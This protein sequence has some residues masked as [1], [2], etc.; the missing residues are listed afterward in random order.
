MF[1]FR[2]WTRRPTRT[3]R[4][5]RTPRLALTSL[6]D[7]TVPTSVT[8]TR[9]ANGAVVM[10]S[11]ASAVGSPATLLAIQV[12]VDP[13][14]GQTFVMGGTFNPHSHTVPSFDLGPFTFPASGTSSHLFPSASH[15][16]QYSIPTTGRTFSSPSDLATVAGGGSF[17]QPA[18]MSTTVAADHWHGLGT[19]TF[20]T[21]TT[22]VFDYTPALAA[23]G[24]LLAPE[25]QRTVLTPSQLRWADQDTAP[26]GLVYTVLAA[27]GRGTLYR[28]QMPLG[29]NSTFT[30][31][32]VD[33]GLIAYVHDGSETTSDGFVYNLR[34]ANNIPSSA[35]FGITVTPA[36]DAPVAADAAGTVGHRDAAGVSISLSATDAE[37][38]P[39]TYSLVGANG[40]AAHGTVTLNG[41]VAHYTP[42]GDVVGP[43][44]FWY[45]VSDGTTSSVPATVTVT[46]SN[47]APG[48]TVHLAPASPGVADPI[49]ATVGIAE[50]DGDP[51]AVSY[52]WSR[53]GDPVFGL[54][55]DT[56]TG[57]RQR[58]DTIALAVTPND[59]HVDGSAA[60]A[61][62]TV[63]NTA[64]VAASRSV[65]TAEDTPLA[66]ALT[67]TDADGDGL[68]FAV[69]SGPAHGRLS[70]TL[71]D[72]TYTPDADYQ[73]PDAFTFRANDGSEDGA[74]ATVSVSVGA[75]NDRPVLDTV[76]IPVL[77]PHPVFGKL[78]SE[79]GPVS[80]LTG[81]ATDVDIGDRQ[82]VAVVGADSA[83]GQWQFK[84]AGGGWTRFPA[85]APGAALL[86][87]A[88]GA[89]RIRFV[90][91]PRFTG[92][93]SLTFKGWDQTSSAADTTDPAN[94]AFSAQT[95]Q[96][97]VAVGRARP[98]VDAD[99][100][101]VLRAVK[102]GTRLTAS[103]PVKDLVGLPGR[104][105]GRAGLGI[106]VTASGG[107]AGT[108]EY[109]TPADRAWKAV[110]ATASPA[111]PL[112]LNPTDKVRFRPQADADGEGVL[113]FRTWDPAPDADPL[114]WVA[115]KVAVDLVAVNDAPVL[116]PTAP[117]IL[118]P[119]TAAGQPTN[120]VTFASLM[121]VTDVDTAAAQFGVAVLA[122]TG[123]GA[124]QY[125][126]GAS[127][128]REVPRVS[129]G[130]ALLLAADA[131]IRFVTGSELVPGTA[132]LSFKAWD[133]STGVLGFPAPPARNQNQVR[134]TAFSKV[135]EV[136]TAAVGNRAPELAD[137]DPTVPATNPPAG[138][139]VSILLGTAVTD[140]AGAR[141]GIAVVG[142][143][144]VDGTWEYS[145]DGRTWKPMGPVS[146]SVAVLLGGTS[147]VRFVP[148]PGAPAGTTARLSYKAWDQAAGRVGDV[149]VDATGPLGV[150]STFIEEA[151]YTSPG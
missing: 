147:K 104:E 37:G 105:D 92:F 118:N 79:G 116:D 35:S 84:P 55:G 43:D 135:F 82:G 71:P 47:A 126:D 65:G 49:T 101:T 131:R 58:G 62:V 34:D 110:P 114:V 28:D 150:F 53:N 99:G 48:A 95:D 5:A 12:V 90:P 122:A 102:E 14:P 19:I 21:D 74:V 144:T 51:V 54:A 24:G 130:K 138:V 25:G 40:G 68:T 85:V 2:S 75:V 64:P 117:A 31:A 44:T 70:G 27:P 13:R 143:D 52:L 124:W 50:G 30:Q 9:T 83:N 94:T 139:A 10:P 100:R 119:V 67:A 45:T 41:S 73:G 80:H 26:A 151:A 134:G 128:W 61:S 76:A 60:S 86:L 38:S 59:G 56:Y 33:S 136:V 103:V 77:P 120:E 72:L 4:P 88:E 15:S 42:T 17:S 148:T 32:D 6:E 69:L 137:T 133:R 140:T 18:G 87:D 111:D 1:S 108:W 11:Y 66:V 141:P 109:K 106:A 98:V 57:P 96:A 63:A 149:G 132:A 145:L 112:L 7:R 97:W 125:D 115:G 46:L 81:H 22:F 78:L 91:G 23:S 29:V 3:P 20:D 129:P 123:P 113:G 127:G 16:H 89:A 93:A 142:T 8:L 36:N 39:L 121:R 146:E 107:P